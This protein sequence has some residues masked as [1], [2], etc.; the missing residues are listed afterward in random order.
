MPPKEC[1]N[2]TGD[3]MTLTWVGRKVTAIDNMSVL[4]NLVLPGLS[5]EIRVTKLGVECPGL[6]IT[7]S[8]LL[9]YGKVS[10]APL[11]F[12]LTNGVLAGSS[13]LEFEAQHVRCF[14]VVIQDDATATPLMVITSLADAEAQENLLTAAPSTQF[15]ASTAKKTFSLLWNKLATKLDDR[16]HFSDTSVFTNAVESAR[17]M[18]AQHTE[19]GTMLPPL[20]VLCVTAQNTL[21]HILAPGAP[22]PVH[23]PRVE[24]TNEEHHANDVE[25]EAS[26]VVNNG[27][28]SGLANHDSV[29]FRH[30]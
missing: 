27:V 7:R 22:N 14:G 30:T 10:V 17:D 2:A 12:L 4:S 1:A 11:L 29:A 13:T 26:D 9:Q 16:V 19:L 25:R 24:T 21:L 20:G 6:Q 15:Q 23:P 28:P 8:S 3:Q 18:G 5:S